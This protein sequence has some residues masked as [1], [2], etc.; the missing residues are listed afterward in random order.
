MTREGRSKRKEEGWAGE[1]WAAGG[2]GSAIDV[3]LV[4][5]LRRFATE[6]GDGRAEGRTLETVLRVKLIGY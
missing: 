1:G 2:R 5:A 6:G 4:F 3:A